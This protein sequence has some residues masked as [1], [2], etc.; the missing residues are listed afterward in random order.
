MRIRNKMLLAMAVP[1]GL[2]VAQILA[3]NFFIRELQDA[4]EFIA[5]AH[6]VIE[7]D[8]Q[9]AELVGELREEIKRLP[10]DYM[11]ER[12]SRD[13][14]R[15][16]WERLS[17]LI[18][19]IA[20][21]EAARRIELGT[22]DRLMA[23]FAQAR[24]QYEQSEAV[25]AAGDADL[26]RLIERVVFTDRALVGLASALNE[27]AVE[28][29]RQLQAAVD[30][31][32][33]IHNRPVIAGIAIGGL[34]LVLLVAFAWLYVDRRLVARLEGLS[35]SMLAIAGGNLRAP[36]PEP[37]SR[38]EIGEMA[39]ALAVFRDTAVEVEEKNLRE[40]H[41][42]RQ[43]LIDAIESISE[44]FALYD[45]DDRLVL[46]NSRYREIL[47]P[48]LADAMV[49]GTSFEAI[50]R[51]AVERGLI[52]SARGREEQWVAKRLA[53]HRSPTGV[54]VQH[55]S[56]GRWVQISER[57]TEEGDTVAVYSD[58]S[59]L[60][61]A[62]DEAM[63]AAE[64][65]GAFLANMSHELR[66]PLNAIIGITEMLREDAEDEGRDDL[67]EPLG[68]IHRAGGHLLHLINEILDLSKI[69]AGRLELHLED[70][71]LAALV[72]EV[73]ATAESLA[74]A[75]RNRLRVDCQGDIGTLPTDATRLRQIVLNLLS[76]ACKF[77][78]GGEVRLTVRREPAAI[79]LSVADTG[80]GMTGEQLGRLFQEFSQA[81]SS[82]TRRYGGTGL[83]LAISRRLARLMGGDITVESAPGVGS[84]FTVRLPAAAAVAPCAP[85][86]VR[87]AVAATLPRSSRADAPKVLVVDDEET[88]RDLM[89]R[90]LARDGFDVVTARD[91]REGLELAR[92]LR[93]ALI[94]LDVLMP[95]LDGWSVL[96]ALKADPVLAPIPVVMLTILDEKNRGYALGAADYLTKPIDRE[97][98]RA[99]LA[100][101]CGSTSRRHVLV[102]DDDGEARRWLARALVA[103]GWQAREAADGRA[104]L[105]SLRE[106]RPDLILLD[107]LMPE[108]DGFEFLARLQ[109]EPGGPRIPVVVVTAADLSEDDH[110]R[111]NGAVEK[112]LLKQAHDRDRLLATVRELVARVV[113][114]E[115]G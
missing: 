90:F 68:R 112:V 20:A 52:E 49:P 76:N 110:R 69:E 5:S 74:A 81:D 97:R 25:A 63:R 84:T 17:A 23:G 80:I 12:G 9:A 44:G 87:E 58:I 113:P 53:S 57:R 71:D 67:G 1:A 98:L 30:R 104:A 18:D 56:R 54:L 40:V 55:R 106:R 93:P 28:L 33:A 65:K 39:K 100:R 51:R 29:R 79:T 22:R 13:G 102:V 73:A 48:G 62:R 19:F 66:T 3:V 8:F 31:E 10:S 50:I 86:P 35:R 7:A 60:K 47:Y 82:T 94:T 64:A 45:Q 11:V 96:Q 26:N 14:L 2:L 61:E 72:A 70:V 27:L 78:E 114:A 32:R 89:R 42:T 85:G 91:G 103:E 108:M 107:L 101:H 115:V 4:T 92:Q 41:Q 105:A 21:S 99:L 88:V 43:R 37:G 24:E 16:T 77:T 46:C 109:A 95:G 38:D 6:A 83:G 34:A 111:L 75:N 15:L 36:L 59:E